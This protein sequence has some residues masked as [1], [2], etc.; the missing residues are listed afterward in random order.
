MSEQ[1]VVTELNQALKQLAVDYTMA[2]RD[3]WGDSLAAVVLFG[4]VARQEA[5]SRSDIDL[6]IVADNLPAGRL[7][8]QGR[9]APIDVQLEPAFSRLRQQETFTDICPILKT[10]AEARRISPLYLDMVEE[11]VILYERGA[12]FSDILAE[13]RAR[14]AQLNA[15]R[16]RRGQTR[17]WELKPDYKP[18]EVFEL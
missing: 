6:L 8:R 5:N 2:L 15:R 14:L 13:L 1:L 9:L 17:Y 3:Q 7:A 11:A 10:P 16:H 18:G 12:F 4:S